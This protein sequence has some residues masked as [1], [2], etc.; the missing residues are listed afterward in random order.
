VRDDLLDL[1]GREE[2]VGKSVGRD[3]RK[4]KLTLPVIHHLHAAGP[5]ERAHA[6]A[7]A[8]RAA[9]EDPG[10]APAKLR[11]RLDA[12]GSVEHAQRASEAIVGRARAQLDAIPDSPSRRTLLAMADAVVSRAF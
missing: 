2:V 1:T 6:L 8:L 5:D 10:D 7:L 11:Q 12:T 4:G 9:H 3:A